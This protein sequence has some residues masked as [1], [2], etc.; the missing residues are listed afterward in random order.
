M[1]DLSR[2]V[3]RWPSKPEKQDVLHMRLA[4]CSKNKA[5]CREDLRYLSRL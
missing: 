2:S 3:K 5:N 4:Q 1:V